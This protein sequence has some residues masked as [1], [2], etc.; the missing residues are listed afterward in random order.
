MF[1]L[2][3]SFPSWLLLL[4]S[5]CFSSVF[6]IQ[7]LNLPEPHYKVRM[8]CLF[9][10]KVSRN[11]NLNIE[12][13]LKTVLSPEQAI[14]RWHWLLFLWIFVWCY[15]CSSLW[16]CLLLKPDFNCATLDKMLNL[17]VPHF[18]SLVRSN[19]FLISYDCNEDEKLILIKGLEQCWHIEIV[20]VLLNKH[21]LKLFLQMSN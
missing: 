5:F 20:C 1:W 21:L 2:L 16:S 18:P 19:S 4:L 3:L 12:R 6:T 15:Y 13:A 10:R 7:L 17:S 9:H 8:A 14:Y 11:K